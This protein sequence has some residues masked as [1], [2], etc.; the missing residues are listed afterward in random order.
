MELLLV[1]PDERQ[2]RVGNTQLLI[3]AVE[4]PEM[5]S[6]LPTWS[7]FFTVLVGALLGSVPA[8]H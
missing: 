1:M 7:I 8:V 6:V 4:Q 3:V 5:S 2:E